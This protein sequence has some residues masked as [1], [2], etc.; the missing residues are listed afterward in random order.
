MEIRQKNSFLFFNSP[1]SLFILLPRRKKIV[2]K[3][4]GQ[5]TLI[6]FMIL[7]PSTRIGMM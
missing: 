5:S 2:L 6:S 3:Y 1:A 4:T 7:I